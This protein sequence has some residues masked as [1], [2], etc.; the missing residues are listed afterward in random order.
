VRGGW[1]TPGKMSRLAK[2][3]GS[4]H[5]RGVGGVVKAHDVFAPCLQGCVLQI[6]A[7][8]VQANQC[9]DSRRKLQPL[10]VA[11]KNLPCEDFR[12]LPARFNSYGWKMGERQ[13]PDNLYSLSDRD[14]IGQD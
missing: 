8:V 13:P 3:N 10:S 9:S 5:H 1:L 11:R 2:L 7:G 12:S 4:Q 14:G 6:Y